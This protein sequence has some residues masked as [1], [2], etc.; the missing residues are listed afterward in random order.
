MS[1]FNK[2]K[3]KGMS[4]LSTASLPDI[5]FILLFF[6]MVTTVMRQTDAVV[7][8]EKPDASE[9][10]KLEKKDLVDYINIG[11]PF[12]KAKYGTE[13]VMQL[14][15]AIASVDKIG[16]W[17]EDNKN[18]RKE[19]DKNKITNSLKV[20]RDTKMR[21]VTEVKQELRKAESL[22]INYS[23]RTKKRTGSE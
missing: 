11:I 15:N 10:V 23:T 2:G 21:L 13:P 18:S 4:P 14:D 5:I 17:V 20:D 7:K 16:I 6:F 8:I 3:K 19:S 1:K 12:D 9:V 22:K